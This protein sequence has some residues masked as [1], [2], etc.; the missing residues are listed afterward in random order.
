MP[1]LTRT[2]GVLGGAYRI[3]GTRIHAVAVRS[4]LRQGFTVAEIARFY[5]GV[6]AAQIAACGRFRVRPG[7]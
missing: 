7:R 2:P 1:E 4:L 6:T 3:R 5:P